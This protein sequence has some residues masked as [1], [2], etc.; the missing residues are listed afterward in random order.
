MPTTSRRHSSHAASPADLTAANTPE[1]PVVRALREQVANAVVLYLNYK[2][3]HWHT[4]GPHFRDLHLMFD[5]FAAD[6]LKSL[7]PLAERVR[8]IGQTPPAHPLEAIELA[9]ISPAA[10]GATM[11]QSVEELARQA[12]VVIKGMREGARTANEH[13]D[14]G[15]VDLFSKFVQIHEK[16]EWWARDILHRDDDLS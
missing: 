7:D 3:Y 14:P 16:H 6:V 1:S 10:A 9:S 13:D 5:E 8:M 12:L 11:R 15:T 2:H 4:E